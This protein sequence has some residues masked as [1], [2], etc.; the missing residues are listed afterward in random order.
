LLNS[1]VI[2]VK[3]GASLVAL[4][5][6]VEAGAALSFAAHLWGRVSPAGLSAM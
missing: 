2:L 6:I 5:R 3:L 4:G 1:G